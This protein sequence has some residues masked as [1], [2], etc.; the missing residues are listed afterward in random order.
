M[1]VCYNE[2]AF[3]IAIKEKDNAVI[4]DRG[5]SILNYLVILDLSKAINILSTV[6]ETNTK[7]KDKESE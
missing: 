3:N 2:E 5:I 4:V 6:V 7:N 1:S